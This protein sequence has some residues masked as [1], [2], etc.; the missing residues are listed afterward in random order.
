MPTP[1][2][3]RQPHCL[4]TKTVLLLHLRVL[5]VSSGPSRVRFSLLFHSHSTEIRRQV[6]VALVCNE[7][8]DNRDLL[9][10]GSSKHPLQTRSRHQLS[11]L[12]HRDAV[13]NSLTPPP[14]FSP[15]SLLL[16]LPLVLPF[17]RCGDPPP[18]L[19]KGRKTKKRR[20]GDGVE[21]E[22]ESRRGWSRLKNA[23][24]LILY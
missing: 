13:P 15:V 6:E 24:I 10:R 7:G 17:Q 12:P 8:R 9:G 11:L 5:K 2:P 4:L 21:S 3:P 23:S 18:L 20:R 1:P 16:F 19:W 14:P 22:S